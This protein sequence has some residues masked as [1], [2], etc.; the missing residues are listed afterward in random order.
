[1]RQERGPGHGGVPCRRI[2]GG[3]SYPD[4]TNMAQIA[5]PLPFWGE[6]S[7]WYIFNKLRHRC[8]LSTGPFLDCILAVR[9]LGTGKVTKVSLMYRVHCREC[10]HSQ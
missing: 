8:P 10:T 6:W 1:M 5:E 4:V 9:V 3:A 7:D 2:L